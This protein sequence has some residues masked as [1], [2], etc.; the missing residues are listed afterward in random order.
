M[1]LFSPLILFHNIVEHKND[2]SDIWLIKLPGAPTEDI[3]LH[4]SHR[5]HRHTQKEVEEKGGLNKLL[6]SI[7]FGPQTF[8]ILLHLHS[9]GGPVLK[10]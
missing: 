9:F 7:T 1:S 8:L 5:T 6:L 2:I 4:K 3:R 10:P